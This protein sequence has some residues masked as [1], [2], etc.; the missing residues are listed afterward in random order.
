MAKCICKNHTTLNSLHSNQSPRSWQS[1]SAKTTQHSTVFTP[2]SPPGHGKVCIR[3]HTTVNSLHAPDDP[4][5]HG[6]I[7]MYIDWN[8]TTFSIHQSVKQTAAEQIKKKIRTLK[9]FVFVHKRPHRSCLYALM[10]PLG[11]FP[12]ET[13]ASFLMESHQRDSCLVRVQCWCSLYTVFPQNI[14]ATLPL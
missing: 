7:N 11:L 2:T 14:W 10:F 12:K 6:N 9:C 13:W 3:N 8:H 5:G 4:L 1:V